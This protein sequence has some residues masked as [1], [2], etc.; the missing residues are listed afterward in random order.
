MFLFHLK[1]L[2]IGTAG[3]QLRVSMEV[4]IALIFSKWWCFIWKFI[5]FQLIWNVTLSLISSYMYFRLL[6]SIPLPNHVP[7]LHWS[8]SFGYHKC[9]PFLYLAA[10]ECSKNIFASIRIWSNLFPR[11]PW[12]PALKKINLANKYAFSIE[13]LALR[14]KVHTHRRQRCLICLQLGGF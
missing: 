6:Y 4:G 1:N 5:L 14:R 7:V 2:D 8:T 9:S 13:D 11:D 10:V 3:I 12:V